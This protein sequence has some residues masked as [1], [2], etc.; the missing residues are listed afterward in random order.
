M[1]PHRTNISVT[2]SSLPPFLYCGIITCSS[3]ARL[4]INKQQIQLE[5]TSNVLLEIK[6]IVSLNPTATVP[7]LR[8]CHCC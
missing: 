2:N 6:P 7:T 8:Y 3:L 4:H 1:A 5:K